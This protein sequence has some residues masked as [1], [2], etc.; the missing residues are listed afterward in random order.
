MQYSKFKAILNNT[1][2]ARSKPDLIEKVAKYPQ[3]YIGLFRP[4]KPKAKLLQN[5]LQSHEI[6]FGDA[7]EA[8]IEEYLSENGFEILDKK[9]QYENGEQLSADQFFKKD[10]TYYFVEQKVR[11]DHDS[12]K[13]RGQISNFEKKLETI[14]K[15]YGDDNLYGFFYFIDP[16]LI[17]NKNYYTDELKKMSTDYGVS[18]NISYGKDF[19][20]SIN[21][22]A[23][24]D[25][26][27]VNL[28]RWKSELPDTPEINFD[29][30]AT[31]SFEEI[32]DLSAS[33]YRKLFDNEELYNEIVLTIFP[34]KKVLKLLLNYFRQK[35]A[36]VYQTL[37]EKLNNKGIY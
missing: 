35:K 19:F 4:T 31:N 30:E 14:I 17:K 21:L 27:I 18:V 11:D 24:W 10:N 7:F 6:R 16:D 9:F 5:M 28:K 15:L 20:E 22:S 32:K 8:L 12:T 36:K 29:I 3:R 2:F 25:E 13:K 37:V 26:I 23:V 33:I 1:I 34:D